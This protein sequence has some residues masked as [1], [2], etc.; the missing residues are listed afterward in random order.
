MPHN[1]IKNGGFIRESAKI[2]DFQGWFFFCFKSAAIFA[3]Q[4]KVAIMPRVSGLATNGTGMCRYRNI[5]A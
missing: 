4:L 3:D 2:A 1:G 5:T